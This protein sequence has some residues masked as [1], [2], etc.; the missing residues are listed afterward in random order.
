M[1]KY[2]LIPLFFFAV[3]SSSATFAAREIRVTPITVEDANLMAARALDPFYTQ[4]NLL[5]R[6][7]LATV[8][9]DG[10]ERIQISQFLALQSAIGRQKIIE[11]LR[12]QCREQGYSLTIDE[13]ILSNQK[14]IRNIRDLGLWVE[15]AVSPIR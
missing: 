14:L 9:C 3:L 8:L 13:K 15:G 5:C 1:T 7:G 2:F 11:S 6:E 10:A 4:S 12:R